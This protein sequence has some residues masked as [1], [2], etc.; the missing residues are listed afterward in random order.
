MRENTITMSVSSAVLSIAGLCLVG[1]QNVAAQDVIPLGSSWEWLH[2]TDAVDPADNDPDFNETWYSFEDYNGPEFNG[3]DPAILGYGTIDRGAILT[4]IGQPA[5]GDRYTAYFKKKF[6]LLAPAS[7]LIAEIFADDGG[8]LYIDGEEVARVNFSLDDFFFEPTD[9]V[10][11][12]TATTTVELDLELAAGEHEIAFSLHNQATTSSDIGFDLRLGPPP[13]PSDADVL[14]FGSSWEWLHPTD[15]TDPADEDPDF[16]TTWYIADDYN[17][18]DFNGPDEALLGYGTIDYGAIVTDIEAP[19]EGERYSAYFRTTIEL[20]EDQPELI[21]EILADDGGVLYIDGEEVARINFTAED[22]YY[23]LTDAVGAENATTTVEIDGGLTAGTHEIAFSLHNQ[24]VTSSDLGFDL[25]I[26]PSPGVPQGSLSNAGNTVSVTA[27]GETSAGT[28]KD[29]NWTVQFL[30]EFASEDGFGQPEGQVLG[31]QLSDDVTAMRLFVDGVIVQTVSFRADW[32][33]AVASATSFVLTGEDV[34][35]SAIN[36]D[37]VILTIDDVVVAAAVEKVGTTTTVSFTPS[38]AWVSGSTHSWSVE[39]VDAGDHSI[40]AQGTFTLP[41]PFF[42]EGAEL[43]GAAPADGQWGTR[44]IWDVGTVSGVANTIAFIQSVADPDFAGQYFDTTSDVINHGLDGSDPPV[45]GIGGGL[46]GAG[47]GNGP[48][49]LPYP[50]EVIDGGGGA[51][52]FIQYNVGYIRIPTAGD[53]TFGV[54]SDDGFGLRIIGLPFTEFNAGVD[55]IIDPAS[56]D[57]FVFTIDTG[58]SDSRVCARNAQPGVY[59]I[60]FFWWERAGGDFG[61]IY[62]A[63]GCHLDEADTTDWELISA[64]SAVPLVGGSG[65]GAGFQIHDTSIQIGAAGTPSS[66]TITWDSKDDET[67]TI[68]RSEGL[69]GNGDIW[70]E[71]TDGVDATGSATTFTDTFLPDP[72]PAALYYRVRKE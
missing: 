35:V 71:L 60:E 52:D 24:A 42:P 4:N 72:V 20:T 44:Y 70:Q 27:F 33:Q 37:S 47:G 54:H 14:P 23:E 38:P 59:R 63:P 22:L 40:A 36:P 16:H 46:F 11:S 30:G 1:L 68:E 28:R 29:V 69:G 25:R 26:G 15:A 45:D 62:V 21:A 50:D 32:P 67:Y 8:V 53:Y 49:D 65:G 5:D 19:I 6:T 58:D 9:A 56:S 48:G 34:E 55:R 3:P 2:P 66:V 39:A 64:T 31:I 57:T 13:P 61:E 10:G 17:G 41:V 12:E 18:P 51:D 7:G 43:V